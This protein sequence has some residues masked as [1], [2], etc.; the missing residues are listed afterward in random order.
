MSRSETPLFNIGAVARMLDVS[1]ATMRTWETRYGLVVPTRSSGGQRLYTRAQI[2]QLRFVLEKLGEGRRP[3]EAH[4]LLAEQI[5]RGESF[6]GRA[7]VLLAEQQRGTAEALRTL[8]GGERFEVVVA[9]D[10]EVASRTIEELAPAVVVLDTADDRFRKLERS[11]RATGTTVL[12]IELLERPLAL[13]TGR[14]T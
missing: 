7:R 5:G 2:D 14:G 12:P 9:D 13:L 6:S 1:P 10:P 11:L 8:F 3:G 4:R